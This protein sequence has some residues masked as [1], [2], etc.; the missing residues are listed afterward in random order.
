MLNLTK[1][2]I[3]EL[4]MKVGPALKIYDLIQQLKRKIDPIQSRLMKANLNKKF[5]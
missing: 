3:I 1:D 5:L 4:G 2:E